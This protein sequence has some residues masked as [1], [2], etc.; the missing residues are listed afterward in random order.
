MTLGQS[1]EVVKVQPW[2]R[3]SGGPESQAARW[4]A[5]ATS[6]VWPPTRRSASRV[7][8]KPPAAEKPIIR[9]SPENRECREPAEQCGQSGRQGQWCPPEGPVSRPADRMGRAFER[10]AGRNVSGIKPAVRDKAAAITTTT[11]AWTGSSR[12]ARVARAPMRSANAT[13]RAQAPNEP[14]SVPDGEPPFGRGAAEPVRRVRQP[15]LVEGSG[16]DRHGRDREAARLGPRSSLSASTMAR[17]GGMPMIAPAKG[18]TRAR[19]RKSGEPCG[20]AS[21]GRAGTGRRN[22]TEPPGPDRRGIPAS[23]S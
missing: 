15:V 16:G 3:A 19:L 11:A 14:M 21:K 1:T 6:P 23:G 22:R 13:T 10:A 18:R 5:P 8:A 17:A 20:S 9:R 4:A 7:S 2:S 12:S